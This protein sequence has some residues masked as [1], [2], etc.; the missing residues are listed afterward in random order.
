MY[1]TVILTG[2]PRS[3]S[4]LSCNILNKYKNTLALLEPLEPSL[5]DANKGK[6]SAVLNISKFAFECRKNVLRDGE[7][8]TR[9]SNGTIPSNPLEDT[10]SD[11]LRKPVVKAGMIELNRVFD[12]DFTL[13]IKHNALFT[14]LLDELVDFFPCYSIIRNPLSVLASW[15]T[16]DLPVNRGRI[17]AGEKFDFILRDKLLMTTDVLDRQIMILNWFFE[18]FDKYINKDN[19]IKYEDIIAQNGSNFNKLSY[20]NELEESLEDLESKNSS[21]LYKNIDIEHIHKRLV[22]SDGL[23]WKYYTKKEID[24]VFNSMQKGKT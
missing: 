22:N 20:S 6:Y 1:K 21:N 14:S 4:T 11:T 12:K 24:L 17:P 18:K 16:V 8:M 15:H 2:I 7:V 13:V 3:G 23:F 5:F 19:I 10:L 9:H